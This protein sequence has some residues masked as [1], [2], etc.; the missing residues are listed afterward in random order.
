MGS[1][2]AAA[3]DHIAPAAI[4]P[5]VRDRADAAVVIVEEGGADPDG[6]V[7]EPVAAAV[8]RT[9]GVAARIGEVL[10]VAAGS[11][12]RSRPPAQPS[13]RPAS[14]S[15]PGGLRRSGR[16]APSGG[17]PL[18]WPMLRRGPPVAVVTALVIAE[19]V[20]AVPGV[21][22]LIEPVPVGSRRG[23]SRRGRN[24]R[25]CGR[26]GRSRRDRGRSDRENRSRGASAGCRRASARGPRRPA[27]G[28]LAGRGRRPRSR[29][30]R[31]PARLEETSSCHAPRVQA[32]G[33]RRGSEG[34]RPL[35]PVGR[36]PFA[37]SEVDGD[38]LALPIAEAGGLQAGGSALLGDRLGLGGGEPAARLGLFQGAS[39]GRASA[40]PVVALTVRRGRGEED[41]G[42]A[43]GISSRGRTSRPGQGASGGATNCLS[44]GAWPW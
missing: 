11:E 8:A 24:R 19:P 16:R 22:P 6:A 5:A 27:A 10:L 42:R 30:G 9:A 40:F 37:W 25:G 14:R 7:A 2:E 17:D 28:R 38:A 31:G 43:C 15:D 13:R 3:H 26:C 1:G 4:A 20:I 34:R 36:G 41:R 44:A 18:T 33:P 21:A 23:R 29:P 39:R 35:A 32:E 12:R